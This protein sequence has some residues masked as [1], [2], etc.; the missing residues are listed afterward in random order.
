MPARLEG[1]YAASIT[2]FDFEGVP[3]LHALVPHLQRLQTGGCHGALLLGTTGEGPS[4][5]VE[6]RL[7]I[8]R[9]GVAE[10]G[11]LNIL[12]GTGAPSLT[13]VITM[14]RGAF[15]AGVDGAVIVPPFYYQDAPL[16]GLF[17]FYYEVITQAVPSDGAVFLYHIPNVSG[18]PIPFELTRRLRDQF[19]DQLAGVKDSSGNVEHARRLC[20]EFPDLTVF[21]GDDRLLAGALTAGGSGSIT[22]VAN[23]FPNLA[24]AVYDAFQE[25]RPTDEAQERLSAVRDGF[26]GLP[27]APAVKVML[28]AA[29]L[30][31][32]DYVRPPLRRLSPDQEAMLHG[33]FPLDRDMLDHIASGMGPPGPPEGFDG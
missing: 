25:G 9:A 29:N 12:A 18:V 16:E 32:N 7:A 10:R 33:R 2:P 28:F 3:A 31:P 15:D 26:E 6:E 5:G 4:L 17:A 19:P 11:N 23:I 22:A 24:R 13:D 20:T 14:T 8:I 1:V 27:L 30:L 21:V